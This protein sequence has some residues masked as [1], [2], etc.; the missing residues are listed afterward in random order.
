MYLTI[1]LNHPSSAR[2]ARPKAVSSKDM[3]GVPHSTHTSSRTF[4][5]SI[6]RS[7]TRLLASLEPKNDSN[8]KVGEKWSEAKWIVL[9]QHGTTQ[10][11][12]SRP[13]SRAGQ[14]S[15]PL[16]VEPTSNPTEGRADLG[17]RPGRSRTSLKA[18]PTS[19]PS[20]NKSKKISHEFSARGIDLRDSRRLRLMTSWSQLSPRLQVTAE[21]LT[22]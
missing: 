7:T 6:G 19:A 2:E 9:L 13:Q 14:A 5:R 22:L 11:L 18:E 1:N 15:T 3:R 17:Q 4:G 10:F 16:R 8:S 21:T 20:K 12:P